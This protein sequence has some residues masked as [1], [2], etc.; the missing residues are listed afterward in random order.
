V[1]PTRGHTV[2][3][4]ALLAE[5]D[6]REVAFRGDLIHEGGHVHQLHQLEYEY[7]DTK[8]VPMTPESLRALD[9]ADPDR[10]LPAHGGVIDD[11]AGD[12]DRLRRR[13]MDVV[14]LGRGLDAGTR[15]YLPEPRMVEVSEHLLWGGPRTCSDFYV[16]RSDSGKALFVDDGHSMAEHMHV[17]GDR[18]PMETMRVVAHHLDELRGEPGVE[19][20]DVVI[21]THVHDDHTCGILHLQE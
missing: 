6:G 13:L 20:F 3:S 8:G 10:S 7:G 5:V 19:S 15:A 9:R 18:E 1:L 17:G 12:I 21:P 4:S 11:P 2:G 14:D 16:V